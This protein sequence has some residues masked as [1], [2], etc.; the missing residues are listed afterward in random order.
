MKF[1]LGGVAALAL[2]VA[3]VLMYKHYG[4]KAVPYLMLIAGA[5]LAGIGGAVVGGVAARAVGGLTT[6]AERLLGV[7]GATAGVGIVVALSLV[8]WPHMK[9]KGAQPPTRFTP[10]GAL[11]YFPTLVAAGGVFSSLVGLSHNIV[12]QAAGMLGTTLFAI[13]QG[14]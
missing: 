13:V 1:T 2:L 3:L 9:P 14:F 5:G 11:L 7:S 4:K 6:A 10:W 12:T 8:L